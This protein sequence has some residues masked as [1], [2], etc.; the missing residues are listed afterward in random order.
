MLEL[1]TDRSN[2]LLG[3]FVHETDMN[4]LLRSLSFEGPNH[5]KSWFGYLV[6]ARHENLDGACSVFRTEVIAANLAQVVPDLLPKPP[7]RIGRTIK[8]SSARNHEI[9]SAIL[10]DTHYIEGIHILNGRL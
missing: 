10:S 4:L 8:R 1:F 5:G 3:N 7:K 2:A 6:C 9:D